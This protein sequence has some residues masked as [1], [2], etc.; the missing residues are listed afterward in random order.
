METKYSFGILDLRH[1]LD[2]KTLKKIQL[3][4]GNGTDP[5][6][7]GL[8]LILIRRRGIELISDGNKVI[9]VKII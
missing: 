1:Q 5:D 4:H 8:I 7:V 6:N 2:H 3:F 9:E